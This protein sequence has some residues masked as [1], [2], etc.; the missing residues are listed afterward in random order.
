MYAILAR[1][2]SSS[3]IELKKSSLAIQDSEQVVQD[4]CPYV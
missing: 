1:A 3:W 4:T 2:V